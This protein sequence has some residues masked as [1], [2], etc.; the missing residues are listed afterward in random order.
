MPSSQ[1]ISC[2]KA[3]SSAALQP[4]DAEETFAAGDID[5]CVRSGDDRSWGTTVGTRERAGLVD[6]QAVV[7]LWR[8]Q[9]RVGPGPWRERPH[10]AGQVF[11]P[12]RPIE[13][14]VLLA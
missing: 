2:R 13:S 8:V 5:P 11:G 1:E 3:R 6:R 4:C 14:S 9:E 7:G 10:A 12:L